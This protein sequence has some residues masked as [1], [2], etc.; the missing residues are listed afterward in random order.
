VG[1]EYFARVSV[2]DAAKAAALQAVRLL[3]AGPA[4]AG[5]MPVVI[6]P[7]WGGVL[8][9]ESLGMRSK[10][11]ESGAAPRIL[12]SPASRARGIASPLVRVVDDGRWPNGRGSFTFDDEGTPAQR[13]VRGRFRRAPV[14]SRGQAERL[15]H[16]PALHRQRPADDLPEL[17]ASRM[18]NTYID[19]G[20]SDPG[21]S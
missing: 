4:P 6:A 10:P 11:M 7:G 9:H 15:A 13:T 5:A 21:S 19:N 8:I 2:E 20:T 14:L 3:D 18:T 16:D 12:T 1:S 17:A